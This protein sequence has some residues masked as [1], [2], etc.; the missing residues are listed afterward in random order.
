M[1]LTIL[2][3]TNSHMGYVLVI[4]PLNRFLIKYCE[5]EFIITEKRNEL[6]ASMLAVLVVI[7]IQRDY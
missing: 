3:D 7:T 5:V 4:P 6:Y 2:V 1:I